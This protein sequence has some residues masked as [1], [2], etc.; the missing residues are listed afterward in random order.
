MAVQLNHTIVQSRDR[1]A[2]A[3]FWADVLGTGPPTTYGPFHEVRVDNAVNLDF[4][5]VGPDAEIRAQHY[6][7]LV[8]DDAFDGIRSRVQAKGVPTWADHT[9]A[10]EGE[11]NTNDG[12]RGFYFPDPNG[13]LLEVI[14]RPY[15]SNGAG[16]I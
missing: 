12:G 4:D 13:H 10:G 15:G 16:A 11:I 1:V 7:F 14:T 8:S 5:D 2:S 9:R 6:A 3:N